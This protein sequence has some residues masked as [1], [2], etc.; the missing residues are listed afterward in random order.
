MKILL[1]ITV[2]Q[3]L[4]FPL[5]F[6]NFFTWFSLQTVSLVWVLLVLIGLFFGFRGVIIH[7]E[8]FKMFMLST[9]TVITSL[10]L[11]F[12]YVFS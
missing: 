5:Y 6:I 1:V 4:T 11:F 12:F 2:L 7:K 9:F 8:D 3:L 10:C